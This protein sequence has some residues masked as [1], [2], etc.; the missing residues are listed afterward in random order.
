MK[1]HFG[2]KIL[3][4]KLRLY[5]KSNFVKSRLYCTSKNGALHLRLVGDSR[6]RQLWYG[7]FEYLTQFQNP[8]LDVNE[9]R[10]KY[11][12]PAIDEIRNGNVNLQFYEVLSYKAL[13][14]VFDG[15]LVQDLDFLVVGPL[16]HDIAPIAKSREEIRR[17]A[18]PKIIKE[19]K[20]NVAKILEKVCVIDDCRVVTC[21]ASAGQQLLRIVVVGT[22]LNYLRRGFLVPLMSFFFLLLFFLFL[23]LLGN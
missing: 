17:K 3:F 20:Q 18:W 13:V 14:N 10:L 16:L 6:M 9:I 1:F 4:F 23:L 12:F 21:S 15:H 11:K 2:H 8:V 19:Y 22:K 7:L 5:I